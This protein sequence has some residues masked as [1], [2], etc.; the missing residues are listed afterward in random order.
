MNKIPL[1]VLLALGLSIVSRASAGGQMLHG[2]VPTAV[3]HLQSLRPLAATNRLQL[4]MGLPLRNQGELTNLLQNIYNPASPDYRHFLTADEFAQRFGPPATDYEAVMEFARS[5]GLKVVATHPN[6]MLL[7]VAGSVP[8]I[9]KA[10]HLRLRV[11]PHPTEAREFYAP[12]AEPQLDLAVPVL[13][14]GGLDNFRVPRPLCH[15]MNA[16]AGAKTAGPESGSGTSGNYAGKD[17]RAAYAPGVTNTGAGQSVGLLEFQGYYA[18]DIL[19]YETNYSLPNVPLSNVLL[20]GLASITTDA[21]GAECPLDIEMAIAMATNLSQVIIYC[22]TRSGNTDDVLNRMATDNL[23]KQLSCSWGTGA[24]ATAL[25][26]FQQFA[27]QGQ[28]YFIASGDTDA[29]STAD[30]VYD[31]APG[32]TVVGGTTLVTTGVGGLRTSEAAWNRGGGVGSTGGISATYGIPLWQQGIN[33]DTNQGSPFMRNVPDVAMVAENVWVLY[34]N[35]GSGAFGGTSCAAPLW[36]GFM[37][38]VNQQAVAN[39]L[40]PVGFINPAIYALGRGTN[41]AAAFHDITSGNNTSSSSPNNFYAVPG[42]DLCTGWGTPNGSNL[43]NALVF[44]RSDTLVVTPANNFVSAGPAGGAFIPASGTFALANYGGTATNWS[45]IN[46]SAW[47]SVSPA[48]GTLAI[49]ASTNVTVSVA[50]AANSLTAG[51]YSATLLFSNA[52]SHS[53]QSRSLGLV[54]GSAL[55]WNATA[56]SSGPLDGS[57]TWADLSAGGNTN[58]WNAGNVQWNNAAPGIAIFGANNGAAGTV[59]LGSAITAG[60]INFNVPGSGNYTLAGGGNTL[61]LN[62]YISASNS[63]AVSAPVNLASPGTFNVAAG[64]TLTVSG[65]ISGTNGNSLAINGPGT[66]SLTGQNNSGTSA[67]MAGAVMVNSGTMLLNSGGSAYGTLGNVA[68]IIVGSGTVL[69]LQGNNAIS[70]SSG[71]ART[72]TVNNGTVTNN[73]GSH[74]LGVLTFNGGTL[75]GAG[76]VNLNGDVFA[77]SNAVISAQTVSTIPGMSFNVAGGNTLACSGN[78]T[79]SGGLTL[80]GP[81][82]LVFSG[83]NNSAAGTTIRAGT[84]QVGDGGAGGSLGAGAVTNSGRLQFNRSDNFTWAT[85]VADPGY[86]GTFI[87]LNTNTVILTATNNFLAASSGTIQVNGGL[88]QINA[89]GRLQSG[90]EFWIAQNAATGACIINGGT[91]IN[92][93]WLVVGRNHSAALGT[94]TVNSGLI[95]ETGNGGNIIMGSLGGSG[96]LT[97]NGGVISN[98]ASLWLG[99]SSTGRGTLNLNG[100][101]VQARQVSR[102]ASAGASALVNLN[103]GTLQATTNQ[104]NFFS[105]DQVLVQNGGAVIDDGGYSVGITQGL[106]NGG[107]GGL[108]KTGVGTLNLSA[109]NTYPGATTVS[110]GTLGLKDA[111]LHFSFDNVVSGTNVIND[112][113]GG[114]ALNGTIIGTNLSIVPGG[115]FGN[116]LKI[117]AGAV[118]AGGVVVSNA[119]VP[120]NGGSN[121]TV[122]MWLKTTVSGGACLYQGDGGWASGNTTFYLNNGSGGGT[123]AGGVRYAGGWEEGTT[124]VNNGSWHFIA[125]VANAGTKTLYVDGHADPLAANAWGTASGT[126]SQMWIGGSADTGDGVVAMTNGLIDEVY[127]FNRALSVADVLSLTNIN[128]VLNHQV[129]PPATAV[130]LG[131]GA[132]L[133][134][135]GLNQTIGSL[136]GTN[137]SGVLLSGTTNADALTVG[138]AASTTFAGGISGNGSVTKAGAGTLTLSGA[139]SYSGATVINAGTVQFG[140]SSNSN[141]VAALQPLLWLT[142]D[143]V[144]GGVVTNLGTGGSA[145]NGTLTGTASIVSGGR[146]GKALN[147]PSGAA[148]A[149]YVLINNPV[150]ALTGANAWT[151]AMWVKTTTAGGVYAYQGSGGWTSGNMTFYLNEGSDSGY[152][153]KAGGVSYA[154]GWETGTAAINDGNWHFVVMTSNGSSK[155]MYVDGNG[156]AVTANWAANTGVGSQL[157]IGGSADTTDEDIGLGGLIDEAYMFNRALNPSEIRNLMANQPVDAVTNLTGSLPPASPVSLAVGATL[158]LAG[159]LQTIA[160]LA[161]VAGGGGSVTNSAGTNATLTIAGNGAATTFSGTISDPGNS[162][163]ISLLKSGSSTQVLAGANT[164]SGPTTISNGNLLVNGSLGT[165]IV[166][167]S[168]GLLGGNGILGGPVM[169]QPGGTLSPGFNSVG[170]LTLSNTLTLAGTTFIEINRSLPTNDVVRGLEAVTFGGTLT[171]TNLGGLLAAGDTF[172]LFSAATYAGA[173]A[174]TNLPPLGNNLCWANR[175][176]EDGTIAVVVMVSTGPTNLVWNWGGTNLVL[177]WP[178]DHTGW[179]LLVQIHNL[180]A[181]LSLNTNDW[182][183]VPGSSGTNQVSLPV[184]VTQPAEFYQLVYP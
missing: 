82:T 125:L 91:L 75:S 81:G 26:I 149:A 1:C 24:D 102:A 3:S 22:T 58:W 101:W 176:G 54:V 163:S 159:S 118:N 92:S 12:D 137:G 67:G 6:R 124:A 88:L 136:A 16:T 134:L 173:F 69:S 99:E 148:N 111:I 114:A 178:A 46:T 44:S 36:A 130:V 131:T 168:G 122:A 14:V 135:G 155:T 172:Q 18:G 48:S 85:P 112:G 151:V 144:G 31:D 183:A 17:F 9:E 35:G 107:S 70:G 19:N 127:V 2:H 143:Q 5:N 123:K 110:A 120:L 53:V 105:V 113:A 170:A 132:N 79:G 74:T 61:T 65:L 60:G 59:T 7:D 150:V 8:D 104:A 38:L 129:L 180:A 97:V 167:V 89:P 50:A 169:I 142:F 140:S 34:N 141:G 83:T 66:V 25:Q 13:H 43:I 152:G 76:T 40:T 133:D 15:E 28:S 87:K 80:A 45:L 166:L 51:Y 93:N 121:W 4:A 86:C 78:V 27:A 161:D 182:A 165:N 10:F 119:V 181:G 103:G 77:N 138:N 108:T 20:G 23:A 158:D 11:Y 30:P 184:D 56:S 145:M 37:A 156:D 164:Y 72:V 147:I 177:S 33:M 106:L 154:Q 100:G 39:G 29:G 96:T 128:A 94:L 139:N 174:V 41:Y 57:G 162:S 175:L 42:Y 62:G 49:G 47:F 52:G 64:Q 171:V 116:A 153:T 21:G 146:Y 68:G 117:G 55:T 98:N 179:R 95:Q 73:G 157:W 160:S 84:L 63:A 126:G 109:T 115:R 71:I 32:I 90:A